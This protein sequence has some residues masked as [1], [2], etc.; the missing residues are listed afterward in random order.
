MVKVLLLE[1]MQEISSFNPVPSD[2]DKFR[3]EPGDAMLG[4]RGLNTAVG[5]ALGVLEAEADVTV[6]PGYGARSDSAGP[7]SASGWR[8]LSSELLAA[9]DDS[10]GGIDAAFVSLHGAMA[11]DG[12]LDPEGHL[13]GEIR[14]RLGPDKPIVVSLDLHGILTA[15]MIRAVDG[16]AI[17]YTYPHRDFADTGARAARVLL[18]LL[19]ERPRTHI[20]RVPIP[21]LVRGN[22]LIT[23]T[24]V[25]G[26]FLA[27]CRDLEGSGAAM[28]AGVMIGNPFTD[29]PE[30][31]SQVV[32]MTER[33][34]AEAAVAAEMIAASFWSER[35]RMQARLTPLAEAIAIAT[36]TPGTVVFSDAADAPSS[37]A[38]GD[39][40]LL[41]RGLRDAG[42]GRRVLAQIVDAPAAAAA[43]RA[44]VGA[45]IAVTLGGSLD[46]RRFPPMAVSARVQLLSDGR[47]RLETMGIPL[48]AGPTAVLTFD[49]FTVVVLTRSVSLFDRA[50]YY[51]N[52]IDPVDHDLVVVKSPHA[53]H[54]MYDAWAARNLVVDVAGSTSANLPTLGHRVCR[55]PMFPLDADVPFTP[56]A[57]IYAAE[58][59]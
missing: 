41:I 44:G 47:S 10:A 36:A 13:L 40:N 50:M 19:R 23:D 29:V 17:Y 14:R 53:E 27:A 59:A 34:P 32:V 39:S 56:R 16:L 57:E 5:G 49:N 37:G 26:T 52:G 21:A 3:V 8:R 6:V 24:G 43:H 18:R 7:L 45:T 12:E 35:K 20:V 25:Y 54:H 46:R 2:Y 22:E 15:R 51:S 28:A 9:V 58:S 48:D 1:C 55:R 11:A 33:D 42:Y 30:L 38:S 31:G 4:Q